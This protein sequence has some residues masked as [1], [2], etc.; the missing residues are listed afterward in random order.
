[1]YIF[2]GSITV[3]GTGFYSAIHALALLNKWT[4]VSDVGYS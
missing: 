3:L 2:S 4:E 1:M